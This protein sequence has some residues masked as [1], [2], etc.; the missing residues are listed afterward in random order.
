[1]ARQPLPARTRALLG[2]LA[3]AG[4]LGM[5]GITASTASAACPS[6]HG[7]SAAHAAHATHE[8]SSIDAE[9]AAAVEAEPT[10]LRMSA[11]DPVGAHPA[12]LCVAVLAAGALL[13]AFRA[14][15]GSLAP[16]PVAHAVATRAREADRAPPDPS[17]L[18]RWRT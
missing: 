11:L 15:A 4:L 3:I 13:L 17:L 2:V 7:Q 10:V 9:T 12:L 1:M 14:L 5:H 16:V 6:T 18:C 8:A